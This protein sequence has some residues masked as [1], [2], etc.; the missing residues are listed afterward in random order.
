MTFRESPLNRT[1][2]FPS[3]PSRE[4]YAVRDIPASKLNLEIVNSGFSKALEC[5]DVKP[6]GCKTVE[7]TFHFTDDEGFHA[8]WKYKYVVDIDGMSYS[9]RFRAF[10]KSDSAPIKATIYR[11]F[12]TE[13]IQPWFVFFH[14]EHTDSPLTG[15]FP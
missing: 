1:A 11:E 13:W 14:V 6:D 3:S 10:L 8:H 2:I 12:F 15:P 5:E 7:K 9:A 4:E